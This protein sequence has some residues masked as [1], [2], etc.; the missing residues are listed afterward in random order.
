[1]IDFVIVFII[2]LGLLLL[3]PVS[4]YI[5]KTMPRWLELITGFL[6]PFVL[7]IVLVVILFLLPGFGFTYII[8]FVQYWLWVI[9]LQTILA[10]VFFLSGVF[11]YKPSFYKAIG[12]FSGV[13]VINWIWIFSP[14]HI[15]M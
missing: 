3:F 6:L 7:H 5:K 1:M 10:V 15:T 13:A 11:Y 9:F 2:I 12:A 14:P 8:I 4:W